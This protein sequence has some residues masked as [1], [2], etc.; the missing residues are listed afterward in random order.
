MSNKYIE[1]SKESISV[2]GIQVPEKVSI[3]I[4][5][6]YF[7]SGAEVMVLLTFLGTALIMALFIN[8]VRKK[9]KGNK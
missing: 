5:D 8:E 6:G 4:F 3:N 7:L 9:T 1:P 2:F